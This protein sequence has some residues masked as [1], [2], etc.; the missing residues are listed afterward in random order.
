MAKRRNKKKPNIPQ[1]T[2]DRA[3]RQAGLEVEED[4]QEEEIV[5]ATSEVADG[6]DDADGDDEEA[7]AKAEAAVTPTR[8]RSSRRGKI[9]QA[10][11]ERSRAKGDLTR[12][13]IEEILHNPTETVSSEQLGQEY[14]HVLLDLRNMGILAAAL[15][16]LLVGLAQFI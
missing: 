5:E 7:L 3:R 16:V 1:A 11:L 13:M 8:K 14:R 4:T 9:S 12:E 15:M 2:L 10:Q 6:S